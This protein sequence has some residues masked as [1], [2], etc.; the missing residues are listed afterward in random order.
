[1]NDVEITVLMSVYNTPREQLKLA[2]E[3]ILNQTYTNFRLI[4]S[5]DCSKDS[6][7]EILKEY[8]QK[9]DRI[10]IF[11]QEKNLGYVGNFEFLLSKVQDNI[12]VFRP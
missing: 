9:D 7:R 10:V 12:Y 4:I 5:D 11:Y 8:S 1:M 6:T 2:I 3:S